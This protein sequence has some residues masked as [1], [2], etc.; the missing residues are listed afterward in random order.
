LPR[1]AGIRAPPCYRFSYEG[2]I[3]V[4]AYDDN[5]RLGRLGSYQQNRCDR[6]AVRFVEIEVKDEDPGMVAGNGAAC[7]LEVLGLGDNRELIGA[8]QQHP[9]TAPHKS[10][11]ISQHDV[12][13][14]GRGLYAGTARSERSLL[15]EG[16]RRHV[17]DGPACLAM[18][19]STRHS[20]GDRRS[21]ARRRC[22]P[23]GIRPEKGIKPE[24]LWLLPT[25]CRADRKDRV[26]PD[27]ESFLA[28]KRRPRQA[29]RPA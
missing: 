24:W 8:V 4:E 26:V 20:A 16:S 28:S 27:I 19:F 12:D 14:R 25:V 1:S 17:T 15:Y 11:A 21:A 13:R 9:Q 22:D 5:L 3:L 10:F 2:N 18:K 23:T 6:R 7:A 29:S